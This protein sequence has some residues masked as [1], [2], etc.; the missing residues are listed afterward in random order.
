MVVV[1]DMIVASAEIVVGTVTVV[2]IVLACS[3]QI[4]IQEKNNTL[5]RHS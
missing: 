3:V 1:T 2:D 4:D 5:G